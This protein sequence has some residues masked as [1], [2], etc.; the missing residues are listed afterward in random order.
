MSTQATNGIA[1]ATVE[2][3]R[4]S[5]NS[6]GIHG[7]V[8]VELSRQ[9]RAPHDSITEPYDVLRVHLHGEDGNHF[10]VVVYGEKDAFAQIDVA[11]YEPETTATKETPS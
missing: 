4:L 10:D 2:R 1:L 6:M 3:L 5:N 9:T 11:P 7:I 8:R